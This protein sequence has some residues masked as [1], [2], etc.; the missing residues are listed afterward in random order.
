MNYY[1]NIIIYFILS[2]ILF[3]YMAVILL[4]VLSLSLDEA[5]SVK[6][7]SRIGGTQFTLFWLVF[8]FTFPSFPMLL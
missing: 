4:L 1:S 6:I 7:P 5:R 3:L 8:F 2:H